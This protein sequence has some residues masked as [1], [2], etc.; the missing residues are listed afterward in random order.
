MNE[1]RFDF[2]VTSTFGLE[3]VER[4]EEIASD[5]EV[6]AE[7]GLL[8]H[9]LS[10]LTGRVAGSPDASFGKSWDV[11]FAYPSSTGFTRVRLVSTALKSIKQNSDTEN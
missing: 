3:E 1:L 4:P 5:E 7:E 2:E 11:L 9:W 6:S 8:Q 10:G